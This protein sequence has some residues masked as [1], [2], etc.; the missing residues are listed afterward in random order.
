MEAS[1][2]DETCSCPC[3]PCVDGDCE[4]CNNAL[5]FDPACVGHTDRQRLQAEQT[6]ALLQLAHQMA[7]QIR[8]VAGNS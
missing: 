6:V 1:K 8:A 2:D 4:D 7:E 5:C 3:A